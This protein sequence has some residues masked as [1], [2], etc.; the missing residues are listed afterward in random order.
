[1]NSFKLTSIS[2]IILCDPSWEMNRQLEQYCIVQTF[3]RKSQ[4][5][6]YVNVPFKQCEFPEKENELS[7]IKVERD[8]YIHRCFH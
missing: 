7:V 5:L 1:M 4:K 6:A 3:C 8:H 2:I